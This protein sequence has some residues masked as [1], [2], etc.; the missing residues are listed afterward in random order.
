M[1]GT[2]TGAQE[3]CVYRSSLKSNTQPVTV[4]LNIEMANGKPSAGG[5]KTCR[6]QS[7]KTF[8]RVCRASRPSFFT[9]KV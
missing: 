1:A 8:G 2:G 6:L 4:R 7:R 9:T 5:E 3:R